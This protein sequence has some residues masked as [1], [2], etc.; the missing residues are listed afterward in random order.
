MNIMQE[1]LNNEAYMIEERRYLHR[2]PEPSAQEW[3]TIEH[4]HQ[5]L[6]RMG[7]AHDVVEDGG[8]LAYIEGAKPGKTVLLR[9]DCDALKMP[10]QPNNLKGPKVCVSENE[11]VCHSCG[12][13]GHSA[14][15]L[16]VGKVLNE[17]KDELCGNV[18][19][20]FERGEEGPHSVT[21]LYRHIEDKGIK[22]DTVYGNHVYAGLKTGEIALLDGPVMAGNVTFE[23][24]LSGRGGHGSRPDLSINPIDC[25]VAICNDLNA[26][27]MKYASP[28]NA[29]TYSL[30]KVSSGAVINIIP[31]DLV[32]GGTVRVFDLKDGRMFL[33]KLKKILD[34]ECDIFDCTWKFTI[35]GGPFSAVI[36][37]NDC[38]ALARKAVA[39]AVG[40]EHL[41]TCEPWMASESFALTQQK[42]PG[43]FG[44]VGITN[45][46]VGSGAAHHNGFFDIDEAG[47]KYSAACYIAY[48]LAFLESDLDTSSKINPKCF[49]DIFR[50]NAQRPEAIDFL[51][52][53]TCKL[54]FSMFM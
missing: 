34:H 12:H 15:L 50:D 20:M 8:I 44:L 49:A 4:L 54:D 45:E 17:H 26:L 1:V 46:E 38:A 22:I 52:H 24:V 16:T 6:L 11:G 39:E 36:N 19:L 35:Q 27:R 9:A 40:A 2:H 30:G 7:I 42:W 10:E 53:K 47:L 5:E 33:D 13:D 48:T 29:L 21:C 3:K 18:V 51:E 32:F 25:F 31:D 14:T 43:V 37:D 23:V 28:F 41:V